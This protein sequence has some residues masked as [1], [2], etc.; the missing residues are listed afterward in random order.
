MQTFAID[1]DRFIPKEPGGSK[2]AQREKKR[3]TQPGTHRRTV[4]QLDAF[5]LVGF[6][7]IKKIPAAPVT[8]PRNSETMSR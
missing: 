4:G 1:F 8:S 3:P 7:R 5:G 6:K 2:P